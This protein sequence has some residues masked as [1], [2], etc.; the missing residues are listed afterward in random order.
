M[1]KCSF[2]DP[3]S[4]IRSSRCSHMAIINRCGYFAMQTSK[5]GTTVNVAETINSLIL[6]MPPPLPGACGSL[7]ETPYRTATHMLLSQ[8]YI[9]RW[10]QATSWKSGLWSEGSLLTDSDLELVV[11]SPPTN[12]AYATTQTPSRLCCD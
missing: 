8:C 11:P 1:S 3:M 9:N 6:Q 4:F 7:A 5:S 12:R 10:H 2:G